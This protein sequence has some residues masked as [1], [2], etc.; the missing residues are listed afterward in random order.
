L[1]SAAPS[2]ISSAQPSAVAAEGADEKVRD[3]LIGE[4]K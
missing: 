3:I 2:A 1:L 4:A